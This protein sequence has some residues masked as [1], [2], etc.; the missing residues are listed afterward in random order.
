ML[1]G[2]QRGQPGGALALF[3][4]GRRGVG[5]HQRRHARDQDIQRRVVA[6]LAQRGAR[7]AHL[8]HHIGHLAQ[9]LDAGHALHRL[10]Q[11]QP[12]GFG[13]ERAG[14][15]AQ[16]QRRAQQL[17][18]RQRG[19]EQ[20]L[21]D[22]AAAGRY[23]Q[24][25]CAWCGHGSG[26]RGHHI[27]GVVHRRAQRLARL[28]AVLQPRQR[29]VGVHQH[30]VEV[31]VGEPARAVVVVLLVGPR[32]DQDIAQAAHHLRRRAALALRLALDEPDQRQDL[33]GKLL[34]AKRK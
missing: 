30:G 32:I 31:A 25:R 27:T 13:Q 9:Q 18:R 3:V 29:R 17:A 20:G 8:R 10:L 14:D 5:H 22:D 11:R 23:Q 34:A 24:V 7:R 4:L 26:A 19:L 16:R 15:D 1:H 28:E 33:A 2:T 6:A 12:L 21:A